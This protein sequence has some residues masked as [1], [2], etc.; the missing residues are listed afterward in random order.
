VEKVPKIIKA[1]I[2]KTET[3]KHE[4][5]KKLIRLMDRG[6]ARFRKAIVCGSR[7]KVH[8]PWPKPIPSDDLVFLA[9]CTLNL[10]PFS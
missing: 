5:N 9:P 8:G 3:Q 4:R 10:A 2:K 1:K 7:Y 6:H